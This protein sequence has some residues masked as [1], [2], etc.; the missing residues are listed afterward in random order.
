[1]EA[2][3]IPTP[4]KIRNATNCVKL[5]AAQTPHEESA[6]QAAQPYSACLK[7]NLSAMLPAVADPSKQPSNAQPAA[8]PTAIASSL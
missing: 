6:K 8:H 1:M 7:P 4:P 5:P 2:A 3:P